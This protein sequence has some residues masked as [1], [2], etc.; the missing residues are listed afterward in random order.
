MS[1]PGSPEERKQ[2]R[3]GLLGLLALWLAR[4]ALLA[5]T[6]ALPLV[7]TVALMGDQNAWTWARTILVPLLGLLAAIGLLYSL[8]R[9]IDPPSWAWVIGAGWYY[10]RGSHQTKRGG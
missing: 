4:V 6:V 2:P 10:R 3:R 1:H 5:G 7:F 8:R 9:W